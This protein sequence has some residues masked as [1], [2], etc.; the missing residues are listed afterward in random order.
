M[1]KVGTLRSNLKTEC[2]KLAAMADDFSE[3]S[4]D[5]FQRQIC[6]IQLIK[7]EIVRRENKKQKRTK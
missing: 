4:D 3:G 7:T 1:L 5:R 2:V 6:V